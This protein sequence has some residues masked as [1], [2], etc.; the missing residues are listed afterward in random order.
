MK[1]LIIISILL[2]TFTSLGQKKWTLKECV[3]YALENNISIKQSELDL[4]ATDAEQLSALGNFLPSL[5]AGINVSRNTGLSF[6]PTTNQPETVTFLSSSGSVNAGYTLFDGLRNVRQSQR[7]KISQLASQYRLSKMKDDISLFVA[8]N[9][10]QV[11]LN[12]ANLAVLISQ[13]EVTKQQ[14]E[15]TKELV[16]AGVLPK[17][18]LLDIQATD[19]SELQAIVGAENNIQ[20]SLIS[21]AQLLLIKDY[22]TF[23]I[24]DEGYNLVNEDIAGKD[25]NEIIEAAKEVRSEYKIAE[26]NVELA[27]KDLQIAKAAYFPRLSA[28]FS[29]STRYTN[30]SSFE[31]VIDSDNPTITRQIGTV[32]ATGQS[33]VSEFPNVNTV[34]IGPD[35]FVN[36][37]YLNDG[38][39]YGLSLNIPILNGFSTKSNVMRSKVNLE[40]SKYQLEQTKLD[41]ESTVYQAFVDAEGSLKSYEAALLSQESQELAY[42]YAKERFDVGIINA[43]DFSQSKLRYNNAI[44]NTNRAK[45]DYIFKLKVL[46]LYFGIPAT[47]LKF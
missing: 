5:S 26:Q 44:I 38:I 3:E 16:E 9:Y 37:L 1:K 12:K 39:A 24:E 32:E 34:E 28:F 33:V 30:T 41:L 36:Q 20:I 27:M 40:R 14:I 31:Q 35:P 4:E 10:L 21:L 18:D 2:I 25:V 19:A 7:A 22:E 13:N 43:F 23:D 29:Y 17:G 8:N 15:Q 47:A 6:N 11:I 45:Y 42:A 46:E